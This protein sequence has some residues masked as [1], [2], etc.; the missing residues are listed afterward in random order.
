MSQMLIKIYGVPIYQFIHG[1]SALLQPP[2]STYPSKSGSLT[3]YYFTYEKRS[4]CRSGY[5][6]RL[7]SKVKIREDSNSKALMKR[8]E[9]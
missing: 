7:P 9:I 3:R 4:Y 1:S 6:L 2:A 5:H 8:V